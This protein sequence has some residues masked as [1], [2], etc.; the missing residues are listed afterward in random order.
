MEGIRLLQAFSGIYAD[1]LA[2][3]K[4]SGELTRETNSEAPKAK[5]TSLSHNFFSAT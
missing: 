5:K 1:S 4:A 3:L 2:S